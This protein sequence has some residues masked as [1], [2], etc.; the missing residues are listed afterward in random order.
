MVR[1]RVA[2][3]VCVHGF[4]PPGHEPVGTYQ[5]GALRTDAVAVTE[6]RV[7]DLVDFQAMRGRGFLPRNTARAGQKH[8]VLPE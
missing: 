5:D 2:A 1:A 6:F 7:S 3:G 8:E 4:R